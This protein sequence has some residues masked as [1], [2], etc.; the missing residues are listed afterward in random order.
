[1]I[2]AYER[3]LLF[4][5]RTDIDDDVL[6]FTTNWIN[7]LAEYYKQIDVI[8]MHQGR[9][10]VADNVSVYWVGREKKVGRFKRIL[11]FYQLLFRLLKNNRY[12]ACFAHMTPLFAAMAGIP[13][14]S[15]GIPLT[16]WFTHRSRNLILRSALMLS[17]QVVTAVPSS[18]PYESKK[19]YAIGHGVD[20]DFFVPGVDHQPHR[21]RVTQVARL[22]EIKNQHLLIEAIQ[23][24]DIDLY[25]V[26]DVPDGYPHA[27]KQQLIAQVKALGIE[28]QVF[29]TGRQTPAQIR[30][31]YQESDLAVNLSPQGLFDKAALEGMACGLPI[32][33]S[34]PAF[35]HLLGQ[36]QGLLRLESLENVALIRQHIEAIL[37]KSDAERQ[38]IGQGLRQEVIEKHSLKRLVAELVC[39]LQSGKP[40]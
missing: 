35:D 36:H 31:I 17:Q 6:G 26:G 40:C 5:L 37:E 4:N 33:V 11:N 25:L 7:A 8:T 12:D 15:A 27:Y 39:V 24:M 23:G 34:N 16:L 32:L 9:L 28:D 19:V 10:A 20:T 13:L 3:L 18:F 29:F 21:K 2:A 1:M 38:E 22:T 14:R 30:Q